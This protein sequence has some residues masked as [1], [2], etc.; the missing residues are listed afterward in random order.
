M[1]KLGPV[2]RADPPIAGGE[3]GTGEGSRHGLFGRR[4]AT[5]PHVGG[6]SKFL[7][8]FGGTSSG[9]GA[10]GAVHSVCHYT[11]Q[12][13]VALLA[14]AGISVAGIPLGFLVDPRLVSCFRR[15]DSFLP[16]SVP[17]FNGGCI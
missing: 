13:I 8:V 2:V 16:A 14:L 11:C 7:G 17:R 3:A 1:S 5:A 9:L 10:F 4:A 12:A 15:W 6:S